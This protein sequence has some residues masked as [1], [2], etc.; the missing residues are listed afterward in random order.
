MLNNKLKRA[1]IE[2][3]NYEKFIKKNPEKWK[4]RYAENAP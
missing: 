1:I 3:F 4:S 2:K